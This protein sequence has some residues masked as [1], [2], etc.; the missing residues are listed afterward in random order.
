MSKNIRDKADR[1]NGKAVFLAAFLLV[2]GVGYLL[3]GIFFGFYIP[4]PIKAITGFRCP[5]CGLSHAAADIALAVSD[6]LQGNMTGA[7]TNIGYAFDANAL[8]PLFYGYLIYVAIRWFI[9]EVI[10]RKR[11]ENEPVGKVGEM[12][13]IFVFAIVIAWWIV[14]NV[15][16]R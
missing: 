6:M 14:R 4:C 11:T 16:G 2:L 8:F 12:I 5:G 9:F 10:L 13:D 1:S 7:K 15:L 3:A